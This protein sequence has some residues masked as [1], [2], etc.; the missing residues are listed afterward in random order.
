MAPDCMTVRLH[1]RRM[2]VVE[3]TVDEP[4]RLDV[5]VADLRTVVRCP[6]CG[7]RTT[8]VHETRP[9]RVRDLPARGQRTTLIWLRRRFECTNCTTRFT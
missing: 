2:R 7:Y 6:A 3:V 8:R 9:T 4:E 5:V 1:L